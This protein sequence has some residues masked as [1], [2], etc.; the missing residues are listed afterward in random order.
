MTTL[1]ASRRALRI[2]LALA[3]SL[4]AGI[5]AASRPA[6]AQ[7]SDPEVRPT[8]RPLHTN[9]AR[10]G[11]ADA[12]AVELNPGSLGLLPGASLELV[13]AGGTSASTLD[14]RTRRGAG[15]YWGAPIWGPNAL[16]FGLTYVTGFGDSFA[17]PGID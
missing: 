3:A 8:R 16:G 6:N 12:T 7:L 10:A 13:A 1:A 11:D 17:G 14:S 15:L 4:L 9:A 5:V 2:R